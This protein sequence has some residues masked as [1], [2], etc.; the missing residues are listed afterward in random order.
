MTLWLVVKLC[1][2]VVIVVIDGA[3]VVVV[4]VIVVVVLLIYLNAQILNLNTLLQA[5]ILSNQLA[6]YVNNL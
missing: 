3:V 2:Y 5:L 6:S 1:T 4:I